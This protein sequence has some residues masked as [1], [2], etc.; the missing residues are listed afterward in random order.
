MSLL[1]LLVNFF[2]FKRNIPDL[3]LLKGILT[4]YMYIW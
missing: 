4:V 1:S 2:N 3:I